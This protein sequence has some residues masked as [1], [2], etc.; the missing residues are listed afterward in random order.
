MIYD[1]T[2]RELLHAV[3][4]LDTPKP[5][6]DVEN[7][8][9]VTHTT[10]TTTDVTNKLF[11]KSGESTANE[12]HTLTETITNQ[13]TDNYLTESVDDGAAANDNDG[14]ITGGANI[15]TTTAITSQHEN[16]DSLQLRTKLSA[17]DL[18]SDDIQDDEDDDE[19]EEKEAAARAAS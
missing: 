11:I 16:I 5:I 9:D 14:D 7:S 15:T 19:G 12:N 10:T 1:A 13:M 2:D 17:C 8:T 4:S 3:N 6:T 18:E